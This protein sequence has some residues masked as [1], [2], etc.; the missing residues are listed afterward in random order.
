M[1]VHL[2]S[3]KGLTKSPIVWDIWIPLHTVAKE[4]S[5]QTHEQGKELVKQ[6]QLHLLCSHHLTRIFNGHQTLLENPTTQGTL[7]TAAGAGSGSWF[8]FQL[9]EAQ[10]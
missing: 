8:K 5:H 6:L 1:K 4:G 9:V 3:C 7:K 2:H 10:I